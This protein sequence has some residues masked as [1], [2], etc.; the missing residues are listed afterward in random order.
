MAITE[1]ISAAPIMLLVSAWRKSN[2]STTRAIPHATTPITAGRT[3]RSGRGASGN[4][5]STSSPR[6]GR[7][8][9]RQNMAITMMTKMNRSLIPGIAWPWSFGNQE[10]VD[11]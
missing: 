6:P 9:P 10:R 5:F 2:G 3:R 11:R 8:A 7:L 1:R 4:R